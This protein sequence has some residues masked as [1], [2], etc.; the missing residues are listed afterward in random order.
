MAART[1]EGVEVLV[2]DHDV[3]ADEVLPHAAVLALLA[4]E[5]GQSVF[6]VDVLDVAEQEG[7]LG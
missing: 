7:F 5:G 1:L 2:D 4:V 3:V 6:L